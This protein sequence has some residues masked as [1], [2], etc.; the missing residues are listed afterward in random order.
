MAEPSETRA[1]LLRTCDLLA[2]AFMAGL[3][4]LAAVAWSRGI[5]RGRE[6]VGNLLLGIV[7]LFALRASQLFVPSR[8]TAFLAAN[9]PIAMVPID[10]SLDP[11]VDLVHPQLTDGALLRADRWLFGETPSVFLEPVLTPWL[12]EALLIGYLS[13]FLILAIPL[14]L[15]WVYRDRETHE[16]YARALTL[17][18]VCNLGFYLLVPAIGPRFEL[19]HAYK[20]PLH[21]VLFGDRIRDIFL[22]TP[23][24]RDCFPS[25]HTAATLLALSFT[26]RKLPGYFWAALPA[27]SLCVAATV[28][29]RF[30]YAVDLLAA[31]PLWWFALSASKYL[32]PETFAALIRQ[33]AA[34]E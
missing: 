9:A 2:C 30:H 23:F 22:K 27:G 17:L 33:R 4:V 3:A 12:T 25:G 34:A 13:Y 11:V 24:F 16:E 1:P 21:G 14:V 7:L 20:A 8:L 29:C 32:K 18:F 15:L 10:W 26:R 28:L 19:L 31:L 6:A 5:P